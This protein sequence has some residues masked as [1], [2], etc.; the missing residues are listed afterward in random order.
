MLPE[1]KIFLVVSLLYILYTVFPIIPD[2]TGIEVWLVNLFTFVI[3][4]ALYPKAFE[5]QAVFWFLAY[6]V[7]LLIYVLSDK[8]LTIGIGSVADTK[9]L[10]IEFAYILPSLSIF[11]IL[12][13][14]KDLRLYKYISIFGLLF[15]VISFLI[16]IPMIVIGKNA[17]REFVSLEMYEDI[18]V[19][20]IPNYTLMHAY[21]IPLAALLYG[22]RI[23]NLW[24][25][26]VLIGILGLFFFIIVNTYIT[27]SLVISFII[28]AFFVLFDFQNK[29]RSVVIMLSITLF[30]LIINMS[31][32]FI[33]LFDF[34]IRFTEGTAAQGKMEDFKM[35]YL[36]GDI[37]GAT[38]V[39]GRTSLHTESWKAFTKNYFIGSYPVGGHSNLLDRLGG[40][41]LIGFVPFIMIYLAQVKI[42]LRL[43]R[44]EE[45]RGFYLL[46]L[47]ATTLLLYQKGI[48]GQEGWLFVMVLMPGLILSF[49]MLQ[50]YSL[51]KKE[52]LIELLNSR[53]V[54]EMVIK[55][56]GN[57]VNKKA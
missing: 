24:R 57:L 8:P 19:P 36:T 46:G 52:K 21:V 40:L 6:A 47:F 54:R 56:Y 32:G 50:L 37:E 28:I 31:D 43:I 2:Y 22:I 7:I 11:S 5:N 44:N 35:I 49:R 17:L 15:I 1:K 13:Y 30:V 39:A 9:K 10:L 42:Y 25:K 14:L 26:F 29:V 53:Y 45:Q 16:I 38:H 34:L 27:T 41:G 3:L 18:K 23:L 51:Y 4:F 20:G 12:Y 55:R 33:Q 48:F